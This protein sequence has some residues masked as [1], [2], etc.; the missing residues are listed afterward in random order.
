MSQ[1]IRIHLPL[2]YVIALAT[3][4]DALRSADRLAT[5]TAR[6]YITA[7]SATHLLTDDHPGLRATIT[8][9]DDYWGVSIE[10]Y[11]FDLEGENE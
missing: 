10:D 7:G 1:P 9:D 6:A 3:L 11:G 5:G 8:R 4:G 2:E